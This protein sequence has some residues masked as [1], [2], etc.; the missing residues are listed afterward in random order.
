[1]QIPT[2]WYI[3]LLPGSIF[4]ASLLFLTTL[5]EIDIY[6]KSNQPNILGLTIIL[7][8]A[9]Y[10]TGF[11]INCILVELVRLILPKKWLGKTPPPIQYQ[12][13]IDL[14]I[15]KRV[16]VIE[17]HRDIYEKMV[18]ERGLFFSFCF[19]ILFQGIGLIMFCKEEYIF[20]SIFLVCFSISTFALCKR[21]L[22]FRKYYYDFDKNIPK[23]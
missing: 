7:G 16:D 20:R 18:L 4:L 8:F 3:Y 14:I 22:K 11:V 21:W 1:M 5:K 13:W 2:R 10:I 9:S 17:M 23:F 15:K 19:S 6:F 12:T